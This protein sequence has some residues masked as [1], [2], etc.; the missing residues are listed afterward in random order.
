MVIVER[1]EETRNIQDQSYIRG[2]RDEI[3]KIQAR[4]EIRK[5]NT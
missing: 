1:R 3:P 4:T 2:D 5:T